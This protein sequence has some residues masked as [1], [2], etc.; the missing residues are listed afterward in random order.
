MNVLHIIAGIDK[1]AGGPTF[2]LDNI[3]RVERLLHHCSTV[4]TLGGPDALESIGELARVQ[5][6][7]STFPTRYARSHGASSWLQKEIGSYDLVVIH[8]VWGLFG[9]DAARIARQASVPYVVM[10]HGSLDPFDL[11]KK[12]FLKAILGPLVIRPFLEASKAIHC[13]ASYEAE[14]LVTYG[15]ECSTKVLPLPV[16]LPDAHGNRKR[17]RE[18]LGI[19]KD[20]FVFLFL[21]RIDYKKG[22]DLLVKALAR[23]RQQHSRARLAI[24]GSDSN[25]Y[26]ARVVQ[27][28]EEYSIQESVFFCGFLSGH[29]KE[30]AFA[31]CDCFVLPSLNEN[32]GLAILEAISAGLPAIIS[33]NVYIANDIQEC[34]W[35]CDYTVESLMASMVDAIFHKES[36]TAKKSNTKK[37]ARRFHPD[38]LAGRYLDAYRDAVS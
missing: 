7:A 6:F 13:T 34:S 10:P 5:T 18:E 29:A 35:V 8:G 1:S 28:V 32:F 4:V 25:G 36:L 12:R 33:K 15:A 37:V 17:F 31:G 22:L 30:D 24:V 21:S 9:I 3:L 19:G 27:W 23:L 2:A 20:D 14:R 38:V 11:A 16:S 26:K